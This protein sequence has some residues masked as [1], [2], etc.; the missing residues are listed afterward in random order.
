MR[1]SILSIRP[2]KPPPLNFVPL[3]MSS[4]ERGL[5]ESASRISGVSPAEF[6]KE[7]GLALASEVLER[8][9]RGVRGHDTGYRHAPTSRCHA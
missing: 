5:L 9:G 6:L 3:V 8:E 4:D 1:N 7:A 2:P